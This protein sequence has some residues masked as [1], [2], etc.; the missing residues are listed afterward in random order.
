MKFGQAVNQ[1]LRALDV[2][3]VFGIPGVHTISLFDGLDEA[4]LRL[5]APRHEQ[6]AGFMADAYARVTQK[7]G[8][9]YLISGPGVLNALTPIAQAW[10]DSQPM[11]VIASIVRIE[12]GAR[13]SLH[14]TPD[15]T[16]IVRPFTTLCETVETAEEL[17]NALRRTFLSWKRHRKLP[18]F[19]GIPLDVLASEVEDITD[20]LKTLGAE[21]DQNPIQQRPEQVR[22]FVEKL[23]AAEKPIVLAGGGVRGS[24]SE[25]IAFAEA[26]D[27]PVLVTGNAKGVLPADHH[28][29]LENT[30]QFGEAQRMLLGSDV[31]CAIG[32]EIS[33]LEFLGTDLDPRCLEGVLRVDI[34]AGSWHPG[35]TLPTLSMHA[36]VFLEMA[37][38]MKTRPGG[39]AAPRRAAELSAV[40]SALRQAQLEEPLWPWISSVRAALTEDTFVVLDSAQL[41]YQ[42]HALMPINDASHWLAPYGLGTL[43]PALPMAIGVKAAY[44]GARTVAFAGDGG[45]LFT[46]TELATAKELD[47]Q[48][49]YVI[50]D[51]HGYREIE[52]AFEDVS[53]API[54]V[55]G[56]CKALALAAAGLGAH[57][58][59]VHE[60]DELE[61]ALRESLYG[62]QLVVIVVS[63]VE[64]RRPS[65]ANHL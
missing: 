19:I 48:L 55:S 59:Q 6:G 13:G 43:G 10:H 12:S 50:W 33:D 57:V 4:G 40:R 44:P 46:L 32:T 16:E 24:R 35:Q 7:P 5:I 23:E 27:A 52:R 60:P 53:V 51:N 58:V 22:S 1:M 20:L 38:S 37:V 47:V 15:I 2:D 34:D 29:N 62:E 36:K 11:L 30:L 18:A 63:E 21:A 54:G 41:A 8:V 49:T 64:H 26:F 31:I 3:T 45:S 25:L 65:V 9:C 42:M 39:S 28:L 17:A 56:S 14:E 61:T